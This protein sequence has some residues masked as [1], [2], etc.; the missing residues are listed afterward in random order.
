MRYARGGRR[1]TLRFGGRARACTMI[2]ERATASV[3]GLT[4]P[5]PCCLA[6]IGGSWFGRIH[7]DE[8]WPRPNRGL[9]GAKSIPIGTIAWELELRGQGTNDQTDG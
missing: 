4:L 5:W 8:E 2:C 1:F 3:A 9:G 6:E 7:G